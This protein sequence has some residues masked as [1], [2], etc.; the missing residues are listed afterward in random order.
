VPDSAADRSGTRL[1]PA[2]NT[3]PQ[4]N[5]VDR[6]IER[7]TSVRD[8]VCIDFRGAPGMT[9]TCDLLVRSQAAYPNILITG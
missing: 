8:T 1:F 2:L 3:G 4:Q 7:Y 6:R 5:G 9:R